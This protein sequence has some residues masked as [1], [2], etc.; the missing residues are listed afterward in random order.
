MENILDEGLY[1]VKL[2]KDDE[3]YNCMVEAFVNDSLA[4]WEVLLK[5]DG[6]GVKGQWIGW[7]GEEPTTDVVDDLMWDYINTFCPRIGSYSVILERL[8]DEECEIYYDLEYGHQDVVI[9]DR[10][11]I[12]KLE[13]IFNLE[14]YEEEEEQDKER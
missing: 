10:A 2:D 9:A 8:T 1:G 3:S 4:L 13:N 5:D 6:G 11:L 14:E 12:K 7:N